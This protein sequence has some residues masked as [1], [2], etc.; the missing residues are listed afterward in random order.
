M[1][2]VLESKPTR[3]AGVSG[4]PGEHSWSPDWRLGW[5]LF[6]PL[7]LL[8]VLSEDFFY[9]NPG[10]LDPNIYVGYFL[11][12]SDHLPHFESNYKISRL[13]WVLPGFAVYRLF[14]PDTGSL[15]LPLA[16]MTLALASLYLLLRDTLDAGLAL[17]GVILLGTCSWFHGSGGWNYHIGA[18]TTYYLMTVLC[19]SRAGVRSASLRWYFLAGVALGLAIHT[20]VFMAAY[21]PG[22]VAYAL[23]ASTPAKRKLRA[24][25][26]AVL[27][28][29]AGAVAITAGLGAINKSTGGDF[30]F[31]LPVVE[32]IMM[33]SRGND[34]YTP[35]YAWLLNADWLVLPA[36][37][38]LGCPLAWLFGKPRADKKSP[39]SAGVVAGFQVQLIWA[40]FV[41]CY[42]QFVKQQTALDWDYLAVS[43][44][45]PSVLAL[46]G[47]VWSVRGDWAQWRPRWIL[48]AGLV[49]LAV[50]FLVSAATHW[51]W[52]W[53]VPVLAPAVLACAALFVL[54]LG[55]KTTVGFLAGLL[56]L[57]LANAEWHTHPLKKGCRDAF[58]FNIEADRLTTRLDPT[59]TTIKYCF[60][61]DGES[62]DK[63]V[64][65]SF[66]AT[67]LGGALPTPI[68]S[69]RLED[70]G[71]KSQLA[72]LANTTEKDDY[73]RR[74]V[75]RFGSLGITLRHE[76]ELAARIELQRQLVDVSMVI[77]SVEKPAAHRESSR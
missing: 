22:L 56:L 9:D 55:R 36:V 59:L 14:G 12:Y 39:A 42:Y 24:V 57:G 13:P 45:G 77:Y 49:C 58:R 62:I 33:L 51:R 6:V 31:F 73:C 34:W 71:D 54:I 48:A 38:L 53:V 11:H 50:P 52:C 32:F 68:S 30:L 40:A 74:I 28:V 8:C 21:L 37:A 18:A 19:L 27:F 5:A 2:L 20:Y 60:D 69:I 4:P 3:S 1:A 63:Y 75:D 17:L 47:F 25:M 72:V 23:L 64:F 44:L 26:L 46:V 29:V 16:M 67:Q 65:N 10:Y 43:L 66:I 35:G 41:H 76:S 61:Y 7:M 15:I 70:L